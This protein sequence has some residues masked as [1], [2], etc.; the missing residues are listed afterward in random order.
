MA[1]LTGQKIKDT[2]DGLLKTADSTTGLP[3]SGVTGIQDG[4]GNNS[5]IKIG[6]ADQGLEVTG[7]IKVETE[8]IELQEAGAKVFFDNKDKFIG[9]R[10]A[11][12]AFVM[13]SESADP[14]YFQTGGNNNRVKI[15][16]AGVVI[17]DGELEVNNIA[18]FD[19]KVTLSDDLEVQGTS[20]LASLKL[21]TS[22]PVVN[23]IVT[24]GQGIANNDN[25]TSFPTCAA[26][27]DLVD[28]TTVSFDWLTTT[29]AGGNTNTLTITLRNSSGIVI[30]TF[31]FGSN[32]LEVSKLTTTENAVVGRDL[33]INNTASNSKALLVKGNVAI[34][35]SGNL[36]I[37]SG[38]PTYPTGSSK[39]VTVG[40]LHNYTNAVENF[41]NV[42]NNNDIDDT[43]NAA[44]IGQ[45]NTLTSADG[46]IAIGVGN[47]IDGSNITTATMRSV[48]AGFQNT[49][50]GYSSIGIGGNNDVL[51]GQNGFALGF[52]NTLTSG[53]DN[54]FA[55]GERNT[56]GGTGA[57]GVFMVGVSLHAEDGEMAIG[58]RNKRSDYPTTDFAKGLGETKV[59]IGTGTVNDTTGLIFT[60]GG[61]NRNGGSGFVEQKTRVIFPTVTDF[62][63]S[64]DSNAAAG[65]IPVGGMYHNNGDLKIRLT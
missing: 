10:A 62:N 19:D 49:V 47:D 1:T 60:E 29:E 41:L 26:V 2:Y 5:S 6:K 3:T 14:I 18:T 20:D 54:N 61:I 65:G 21:N 51:T 56:Q 50:T 63:F 30:E 37:S 59:V 13:R 24:E 31:F 34:Q 42:G 57:N 55:I 40:D 64:S 38:T 16:G 17:I 25:D 35:A 23:K 27:K 52:D 9:D 43:K 58:Y 45:N 44:A 53:G 15:T 48:A 8:D 46:S 4:L 33:I 39:I 22:N 12:D 36:N 28:G 11:D 7:G 32:G